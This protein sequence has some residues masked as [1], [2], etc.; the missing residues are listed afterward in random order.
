MSTTT[1]ENL[2]WFGQ[3]VTVMTVMNGQT[4][5]KERVCMHLTGIA[6]YCVIFTCKLKY[7]YNFWTTRPIWKIFS[8]AWSRNNLPFITENTISIWLKLKAIWGF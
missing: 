1:V 5:E 4:N 3:E 2:K 7:G 6:R 8:A